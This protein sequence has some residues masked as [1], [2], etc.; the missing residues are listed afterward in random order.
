MAGGAQAERLKEGQ[1][2]LPKLKPVLALYQALQ[3]HTQDPASYHKVL[4]DHSRLVTLL[5][6]SKLMTFKKLYSKVQAMMAQFAQ[7][8]EEELQK[9]CTNIDELQNLIR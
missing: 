9:P 6:S 7:K 1:Q 2:G 5:S 4:F 3:N 8:L